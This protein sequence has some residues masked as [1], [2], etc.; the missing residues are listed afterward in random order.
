M[1]WVSSRQDNEGRTTFLL[2]ANQTRLLLTAE[3]NFPG[4]VK[5]LQSHHHIQ[6]ISAILKVKYFSNEDK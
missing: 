1:S 4:K 6:W 3:E 2:L 5:A